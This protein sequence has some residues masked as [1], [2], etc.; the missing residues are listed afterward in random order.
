[1]FSYARWK[2]RSELLRE[3]AANAEPLS[4]LPI[5]MHLFVKKFLLWK[6]HDMT[7]KQKLIRILVQS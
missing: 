1:M 7:V 6:Y 3:F 5:S 2:I 4:L